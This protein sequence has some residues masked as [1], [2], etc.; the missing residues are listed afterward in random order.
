[1]AYI[2]LFAD[3][4]ILYCG[5]DGRDTCQGLSDDQISEALLEEPILLGAAKWLSQK[6]DGL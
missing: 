5:A 2:P 6:S 4:L 3:D 1:M